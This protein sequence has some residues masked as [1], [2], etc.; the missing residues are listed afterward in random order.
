M[1]LKI[2]YRNLAHKPLG[3]TLSIALLAL[4]TGIIS[5]LLLLQTRLEQKFERDLKDIDLV[6]GAKGSPLQLVLSA[7]YHVD[8]PTGNIPLEEVEKLRKMRSISGITPLAYGDSY[9][10]FRIL[11]TDTTFISR[12]S[13]KLRSGRMF[14]QPLEA[15]IGS[16][17]AE[18]TGLQVGHTFFS[19]HGDVDGGAQHDHAGYVV[20]GILERSNTVLDNLLLTDVSSVWSIHEEGHEES[21]HDHSHEQDTVH[22]EITAALVKARS[23]HS[24]MTLPMMIN[25]S[26]GMQAASPALEI[27]RLMK[28]MGI[29]VT[30]LQ[31]LALGIMLISGFSVFIALYNRLRERKYELAL[32]RSMGCSRARLFWMLLSEGMLLALTGFAG[33]LLLS[34]FGLWI[35]NTGA[36]REFHFVFSYELVQGELWLLATTVLVGALAALVPAVSAFRMNLSRALADA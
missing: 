31:T 10:R 19:T 27:N 18:N 22:R 16:A 20:T 17:V 5:M 2:I 35:L 15:V 23:V 29:G 11:G 36:A 8:A 6:V 14:G 34:R 25:E 26:T 12:Y 4:S 9:Q 33:G 1:L 7:V 21:G 3:A 13:G 28:M 32:M 24:A 30:A